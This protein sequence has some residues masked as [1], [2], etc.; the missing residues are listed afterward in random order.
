MGELR[1]QIQ[2]PRASK[3]PAQK[4]L[5]LSNPGAHFKRVHLL[6]SPVSL[7]CA[8]GAICSLPCASEPYKSPLAS[9][10][11]LTGARQHIFSS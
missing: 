7:H 4:K 2:P 5:L 10:C 3:S 9:Q 1:S 11:E 8:S 6:A